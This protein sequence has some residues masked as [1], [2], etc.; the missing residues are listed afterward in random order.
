[1]DGLTLA[2]R[3]ALVT[4]GAG[5]IGSAIVR[6]LAVLGATVAVCDVNVDGARTVA[7]QLLM[8]KRQI[9]SF[10]SAPRSPPRQMGHPEFWLVEP[11]FRPAEPAIYFV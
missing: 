5:G 1:M 9:E 3:I 7:A 8:H 11:G 4:G 6:D 10:V 2:G